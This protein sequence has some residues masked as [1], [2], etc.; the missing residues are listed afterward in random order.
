MQTSKTG[1]AL[2]KL[3]EGFCGTAYRC[4]AEIKLYNS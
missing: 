3:N 4:P 2:I 1:I